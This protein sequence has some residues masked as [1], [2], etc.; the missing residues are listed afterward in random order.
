MSTWLVHRK[1]TGGLVPF[2]VFAKATDDSYPFELAGGGDSWEEAEEGL[3]R[4][5]REVAH[6]SRIL[7]VNDD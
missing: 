3:I 6:K 1:Y 2:K 4:N 5:I 7:K